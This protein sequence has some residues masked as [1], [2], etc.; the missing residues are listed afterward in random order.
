MVNELKRMNV[1]LLL[2]I[3]ALFL[4]NMSLLR[5][6]RET[7]ERAAELSAQV[8]NLGSMLGEQNAAARA[9]TVISE[10]SSLD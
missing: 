4:L 1:F 10:V 7:T 2:C 5:D 9:K 6:L 8:Y 3:V